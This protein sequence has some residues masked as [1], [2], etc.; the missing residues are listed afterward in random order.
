MAVVYSSD[1][2]LWQKDIFVWRKKIEKDISQGVPL[3][4]F[5]IKAEK[6]KQRER[7]AEIEKVKKRRE[8]RAIEKAQ[9]EEEMALLARER[10]RA[11][12]QDWEKKEEEFHFDQS[13]VRSEIRLREGRTKPIDILSK[14]LNPLDDFDIEIN[15]PYMVLKLF[16][17]LDSYEKVHAYTN[18]GSKKK[19]VL[20][21]INIF[22]YTICLPVLY[23]RMS[24]FGEVP[25]SA[26][27]DTTWVWVWNPIRIRHGENGYGGIPAIR[28]LIFILG[29]DR[30]LVQVYTD[31]T[32]LVAHRGVEMGQGLHTK[33]AQ[34]AASSFN[35]SLCSVFISET[36]TDNVMN[37]V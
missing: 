21:F 15:E 35:I 28:A 10:A 29:C 1:I 5:S 36:S 13:K 8:E 34:V 19:L 2:V 11:E 17:L 30:A 14:Q 25:V 27:H 22:Y 16:N 6:K 18:V 31:G 24:S 7:M 32:V 9:H 37:L 3:D 33:V 26:R 23:F 12:F 20:D 4:M